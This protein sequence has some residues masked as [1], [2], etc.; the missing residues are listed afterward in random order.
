[1]GPLDPDEQMHLIDLAEL[2]DGKST[3]NGP[4]E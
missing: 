4:P 3:L 1:M 2:A